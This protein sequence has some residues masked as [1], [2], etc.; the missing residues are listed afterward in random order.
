MYCSSWEDVKLIRLGGTLCSWS[1]E[2]HKLARDSSALLVPGGTLKL[3]PPSTGALN[4]GGLGQALNAPCRRPLARAS[5]VCGWVGTR[6]PWA[7]TRRPPSVTPGKGTVVCA[8]GGGPRTLGVDPRTTFGGPWQ[9]H[10][11]S[12]APRRFS[13]ATFENRR[14]RKNQPFVCV[15]V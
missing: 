2:D 15:C 9:G 4:T 14:G 5:G 11:R 10:R 8:P 12:A 1:R 3:I 13:N 7:W 6:R